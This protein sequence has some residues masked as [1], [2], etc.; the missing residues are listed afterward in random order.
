VLAQI[1]TA[2]IAAYA[3][4]ESNHNGQKIES[5]HREVQEIQAYRERQLDS[6]G[7]RVE[8]VDER[9]KAIQ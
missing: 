5:N 3:A 7:S 8:K 9:V 4:Y 1:A 6:I 2:A